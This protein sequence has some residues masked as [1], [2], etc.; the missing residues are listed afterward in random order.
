MSGLEE[1]KWTPLR[2]S[3]S[4]AVGNAEMV[5]VP[6]HD[7]SLVADLRGDTRGFLR[8]NGVD[9]GESELLHVQ[10]VCRDPAAPLTNL[11]VIRKTCSLTGRPKI[12]LVLLI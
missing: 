1:Q 12:S 9:I 3:E 6:V 4:Y 11:L 7:Q 10:E 5:S 2:V 8:K